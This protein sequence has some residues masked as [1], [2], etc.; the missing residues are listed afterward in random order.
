MTLIKSIIKPV[1]RPCGKTEND[2]HHH[3]GGDKRFPLCYW[4][5]ENP[6]INLVNLLAEEMQNYKNRKIQWEIARSVTRLNAK[7]AAW[8]TIKALMEHG[9]NIDCKGYPI[10]PQEK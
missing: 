1:F 7:A 5:E 10:C 6:Y 4:C 8:Q 3:K 9:Y 2:C